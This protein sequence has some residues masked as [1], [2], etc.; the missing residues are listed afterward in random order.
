MLFNEQVGP[1]LTGKCLFCHAG[2]RRKG[3]L[4]LTRRV[5]ALAGGEGGAAVVPGQP[6]ESLMF[7]KV[8]AGEMPPRNPLRPEQVTAVRQWIEAGAPYPVEPLRPGRAGPDWWSLRPIGRPGPPR[9]YDP[10]VR[11]PID[12][13]ILAK[14][15]E[16]GLAPSPEA[17]RAALI[18][19]VSFDLT[20]LPPT[21][22]ETAAFVADCAPDAYERLVD[23][24]LESPHYGERWG[25][26]WL[27]VV[28]F[29]ESHG[30]E[31]NRLRPDAWP[32]RDYVIRAFNRDT[33]LDRFVLEQLAG[34]TLAGADWLT[35]SATGFCVAGTHDMIKT[36]MF[37]SRLRQRADDLDDMITATGTAFLGLTV[38]CARCHDHK[39]DPITQRDYYGL[40]AV[41]AGVFHAQRE[42]ALDVAPVVRRQAAEIDAEME[43][44]VRELDD[45]EPLARPGLHE[46]GRPA[47]RMGRNVERFAPAPARFVRFAIAA[48]FD[49]NEAGLDELEVWT[50]GD[51][52]C[53]VALSAAGA[54][55]SAS[56]VYPRSSLHKVGHLNDGL[57]GEESSWVAADRG[58]CWVEVELATTARIDRIVWSRDRVGPNRDRIPTDYTIALATERG[59]WSVVASSSDRAPFDP[60][61]PAKLQDRTPPLSKERAALA[62]RQADLKARRK[63]LGLTRKVYAGRF[64]PAEPTYL[65]VRGDPTALGDAVPPSA[66]AA[67]AP[68][69]TIPAD[70]PEAERRLALAAWL[71]DRSNP[72]PARVMVNRIWHYHFGQG[73]VA[74][75]SDFGYNG[76]PPTHAELLDWLA[77]EY[78]DNGLRQKPLHRLI[79]TSSTYR[80]SSRPN[81]PGLARD[82]GNRW[83]WRITPRRLEAE[84]IRDAMLTASGE[85]N[86][87][88]GG[89]GYYFWEK[90]DSF[91]VTFEPKTT[92]G[93]DEFRRMVYQ[94]R[95]KTQQD[96]TFGAFDCADG[97]LVTP[98]RTVSTT[99]LQALNLLNSEFVIAQSAAFA[100]R[101]AREAG[102]Q[103][104]LRA[105]R[106]WQI[107]F[108]RAPTGREQAA[109]AA[110]IAEHGAAAFCRA[111]YNANEFVY[112]P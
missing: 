47:V 69:L 99:A 50:A 95:P 51:D 54:S 107:A 14:L 41:L 3:G 26:H 43:Q 35:Q 80:Q 59:Q 22:E 39:F 93:P 9:E 89:P 32:Y 87:R 28:R 92:L 88:M 4:D 46:P 75:P 67:V 74:T 65:L 76:S 103:P 105:T 77:R 73:I 42:I 30:Y 96:P 72:L 83:L 31:N 45:L 108:G 16:Q 33:P 18:R 109:S 19:R 2:E 97:A 52:S 57:L 106:G 85:L 61:T 62:K 11:T 79:V 20:G 5:S 6:D 44:V 8:A 104:E 100:D 68:P 27:D 56:S 1:L 24:L 101:L 66:L 63:S 53:N 98:R 102:T 111:L 84:A 34:D 15:K 81:E 70:A 48:T 25:R 91:I 23:R 90:S 82:A 71:G 86:L 21:P 38:N 13:F 112:V 29:G 78:L 110:F 36:F 58:P 49:N 10:W 64:L 55:A 37:E 40:Q 94:Y 7:E 60:K 17:G 12:A